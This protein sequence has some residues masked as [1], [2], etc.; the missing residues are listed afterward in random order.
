MVHEYGRGTGGVGCTSMVVAEVPW[1]ARMSQT[2]LV[3]QV[4]LV[5]QV[6]LVSR[7]T[8]VSHASDYT[9]VGE[10]GKACC[11]SLSR[12]ASISSSRESAWDRCLAVRG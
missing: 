1:G 2:A 4:A 11:S 5:L 8:F 9:Y 6:A 3:P 7:G 10:H 12:L